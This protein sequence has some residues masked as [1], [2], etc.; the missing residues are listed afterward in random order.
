MMKRRAFLALSSASVLAF[1]ARV[2]AAQTPS[3]VLRASSPGGVLTVEAGVDNDG[4][5]VYSV[6]RMGR[7][8]VTSSRLGYL[9]T[10]GV[11]L[12]AT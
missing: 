7:P 2:A 5:P 1:G 9:L 3:G 12:S 6:S 8:V 4:R 11:A 10:D